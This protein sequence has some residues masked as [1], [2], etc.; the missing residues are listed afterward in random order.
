MAESKRKGM[1]LSVKIIATSVAILVGVVAINYM[2]FMRGYSRDTQAGLVEVAQG[3]TAVADESKNYASSMIAN[4]QVDLDALV[5][6]ALEHVEKGGDYK[7]TR[8]FHAIPVI[9]GW[10]T[11]KAAAERE[12]LEFGVYAFEARNKANEPASGSFEHKLLT[13]LTQ[14]VKT[15][16]G[17]TISRVNPETNKLHY[18]RAI[19]LDE[20]C[21][22]CHGDPARY[23]Q[24][25]EDGK[26]DGLD[27]LGFKMESWPTG[28]M[29]G[30]YELAM[31]LDEMDAQIAGFFK[32]GMMITVPVVVLA[33]GGFVFLLRKLLVRPLNNLV[34]MVKD[35]ATGDGDLTKRLNL[36]RSDEIGTL[37]HWFDTFMTNLHG[38]ISQVSGSTKEVAAAATEIAASAE[39]MAA[40][41]T[42]QEEQTA[43]V[44]A[45]VEEMA[46][47]VTEVAR[48]STDCSKASQ[49]SQG[50]AE[51]GG[52]VVRETVEEIRQIATDVAESAASV[53]ELGRKGEKIG[54]IIEVI[55]DIADQTN[56]LALNAAIEAA[57]AGEHGRGFAVV[58]DEVRKL[59]ER[60]QTATEEVATSI[61][62]IQDETS[63]AVK[64]IEAGS[65]RVKKGVD[66]AS[67]AGDALGRIV[68]SSG[69]VFGMVQSIAAAAEQQ[70]AASEEIAR[71]VEAISAVT[72]ESNEGASQAA[73]A[74]TSLSEQAESLQALVG[75][76]R[77]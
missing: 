76:F 65:E 55:N 52:G 41:L 15:G 18:M 35:V 16:A 74:A 4:G 61:R 45:A 20:S 9:V 10:N 63:K 43:Q 51:Q 71:S 36:S 57:R 29:H 72:R 14:Q 7:D 56:L 2:V 59:A 8:F 31:P 3:F 70:S 33:L 62:E 47:S 37:G 48:K 46:Q 40:G 77:L 42:R 17:D 1:G 58:A 28:Y 64:R 60:T 23:D 73:R 11:A 13:D 22:M 19:R 12:N 25:D 5:D 24:R 66:L 67:S 68:G 54:E 32:N 69:N 6:E 30:A 39:E 49:E 44:S 34:A 38:I 50:E 53:A 75:R 27:V 21:M 26:F